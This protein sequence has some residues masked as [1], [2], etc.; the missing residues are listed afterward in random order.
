MLIKLCMNFIFLALLLRKVRPSSFEDLATLNTKILCGFPAVLKCTFEST[1]HWR[2]GGPSQTHEGNRAQICKYEEKAQHYSDMSAQLTWTG[3]VC[4]GNSERRDHTHCWISEHSFYLAYTWK[5]NTLN[6]GQTTM[7]YLDVKLIVNFER[8]PKI[9]PHLSKQNFD[10]FVRPMLKPKL[11]MLDG[12]LLQD[13]RVKFFN[14]IR[15]P[16]LMAFILQISTCSYVCNGF[17]H[18]IKTPTSL[19]KMK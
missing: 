12:S 11:W 4:S 9:R 10:P 18:Q 17:A 14:K 8:L 6:S 16:K 13:Q 19:A 1:L 3:C 2:S 7:Y 5:E 15:I